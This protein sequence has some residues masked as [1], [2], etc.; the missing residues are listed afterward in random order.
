MLSNHENGT[1]IFKAYNYFLSSPEDMPID[2][3]ERGGRKRER[4][5]NMGVREKLQ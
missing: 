5:R 4:E 2:F 3:L 1:C